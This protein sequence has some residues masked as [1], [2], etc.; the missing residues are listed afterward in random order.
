MV[1]NIQRSKNTLI[2]LACRRHSGINWDG[3]CSNLASEASPTYYVGRQVLGIS[4]LEHL[5]VLEY[6]GNTKIKIKYPAG[7]RT[8]VKRRFDYCGGHRIVFR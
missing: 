7:G 3:V 2:E 6:E 5:K 1:H 8:N 4:Q